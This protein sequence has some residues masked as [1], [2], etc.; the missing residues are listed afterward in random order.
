MSGQQVAIA[1]FNGRVDEA[2]AVGRRLISAWPTS[3]RPEMSSMCADSLEGHD[4]ADFDAVVLLADRAC[5]EAV[6]LTILS[7]LEEAGLPVMALL[8]ERPAKGNCFEFGGALVHARQEDDLLLVGTLRGLGQRQ[9]EVRRLRHEA[10]LAQRF[11][12]GIEGQ[13][14]K[15]H[16]ELQ[17]AAMVQREFLP[18]ELPPLHGVEFSAMWRP[19]NYVSGDLYDVIRLDEDHVGLFVA[20][21]IGHGVPAAL[22]TMAI[23]R[24]LQVKEIEGT[25]YRLVPPS[26]VLARLNADMIRRQSRVTRFATAVYAIVDCARRTMTIAGGGHPPPMLLRGDGTTEMIET[27]GGLIGI[28]PDEDF[29]EV[30]V[31]LAVDD[32]LLLYSDGF[33]QAFPSDEANS[34]DYKRRLPT[35]RYLDEFQ[36]LRNISSSNQMIAH[37][38]QRLNDQCGSL[39]QADDLTLVCMLLRGTPADAAPGDHGDEAVGLA[40]HGS[41]GPLPLAPIETR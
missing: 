10:A 35:T 41:G 28:F 24:S 27:T 30:E 38:A 11:R 33:E 5:P 3:P 13:M 22:M 34:D 21:A 9:R 6:A 36:A 14:A 1:A 2:E 15:M 4:L 12:G 25:S 31:E 37:M 39:H 40:L 32:R 19:A 26:E 20:D 29:E 17:L 23:Y 18:K 8:D 16:D 7:M